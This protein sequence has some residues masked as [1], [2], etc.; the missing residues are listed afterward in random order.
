M[1]TPK[2]MTCSPNCGTISQQGVFTA[3]ATMPTDTFPVSSGSTASTAAPTVTVVVSSA[4]DPNEF[5][6]A[7]ITL[8]NSTTNPLTFTGIH[9]TTIAAGGILQDIFLDA[10]NLRNTTPITFTP[11]GNNQ[12]AQVI[13]PSEVFTIPITLAYCTPSASGVT[14]VVTCNASIMTRIRLNGA[15]LANAGVG[16]ISLSIIFRIPL[17]PGIPSPSP[18]L[19]IWCMRAPRS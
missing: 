2:G 15:Q 1:A 4:D 10:N 7:T 8:V 17:I 11:P 5:A 12:T 13:D 9:P 18:T 6:E 16:Q 19:S 3:P 14:P